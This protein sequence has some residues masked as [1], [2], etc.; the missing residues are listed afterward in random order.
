MVR[1][2]CAVRPARDSSATN[3][4]Q[5]LKEYSCG[6]QKSIGQTSRNFAN[7]NTPAAKEQAKAMDMKALLGKLLVDS[8]LTGSGQ[9]NNEKPLTQHI[10]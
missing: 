4:P 5:W 8:P 10:S 9:P 6:Q 2:G 3:Y 7:K 1:A